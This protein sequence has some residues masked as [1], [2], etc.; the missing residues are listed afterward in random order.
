MDLSGL[1]FL[2]LSVCCGI[3][4]LA[5]MSI[6]H[7]AVCDA[8]CVCVCM[9]VCGVYVVVL[10][11]ASDFAIIASINVITPHR[12]CGL[13]RLVAIQ[14]GGQGKPTYPYFLTPPFPRPIPPASPLS[15]SLSPPFLSLPDLLNGMIFLCW[16]RIILTQ[17]CR[18][19]WLWRAF[20]SS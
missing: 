13:G 2:W 6:L 7:N 15:L 10:I 14:H 20:S 12:E 16:W 11:Y 9:C 18:W 17:L 3:W 19:G 8:A 4:G 1:V 5:T